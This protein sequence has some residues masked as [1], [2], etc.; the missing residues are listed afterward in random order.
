M[1]IRI[2]EVENMVGLTRSEIYRLVREGDF[3][4]Q[5]PFGLRAVAWVRTEVEGWVR[6]KIAERDEALKQRAALG[7]RLVAAKRQRQEARRLHGE[8]KTDAEIA[9]T[10]GMERERVEKII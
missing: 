2:A 10:L 8:G 1:L 9:A 6:R 3:P 5:V 4:K 7:G